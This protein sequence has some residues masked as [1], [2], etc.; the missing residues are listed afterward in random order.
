MEVTFKNWYVNLMHFRYKPEIFRV[1]YHFKESGE[2]KRKREREGEGG[3]ERRRERGR[4]GTER[5]VST[6]AFAKRKKKD[7][8]IEL[9]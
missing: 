5:A 4:M 7:F 3:R 6:A 2:R 9:V 8:Q 1:T